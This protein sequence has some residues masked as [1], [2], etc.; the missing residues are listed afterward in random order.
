M[1]IGQDAL[2]LESPS[3]VI[4]YFLGNALVS[5]RSKKQYIVSRFSTEAEYRSM[6]TTT[7]GII[8]LLYLLKDLHVLHDKPA[9]IYC[10]N[11]AAL[12]IAVNKVFHERTKHIE[13]D[14]HIVRSKIQD[15]TIKTY[16][17]TQNQLP[18]MFTKALGVENYLRLLRKLGVI[19]IFGH[20]VVYPEVITHKVEIR[21]CS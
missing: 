19:N 16:V 10:D 21:A 1:Q 7:C 17:S 5:W 3:Q 8:Q 11:Q 12:H 20:N 14:C 15:G 18:D 13:V 2:I 6:A 9:L 4:V